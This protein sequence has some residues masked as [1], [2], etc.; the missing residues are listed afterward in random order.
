L[1]GLRGEG[2][3]E[4]AEAAAA[5]A[6]VVV[7]ALK[8]AAAAEACAAAPRLALL[9]L[10]L[11]ALAAAPREVAWLGEE[12]SCTVLLGVA[13]RPLATPG[14]AAAAAAPPPLLPLNPPLPPPPAMLLR[15]ELRL[16]RRPLGAGEL[17]EAGTGAG[18]VRGAPAAGVA[19]ISGSIESRA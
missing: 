1:E 5:A 19:S 6:E 16:A 13:L 17:A 15:R 3:V 12:G 7:V 10:A 4:P 9:A 11:A 18:S 8:L 2:L 14:A